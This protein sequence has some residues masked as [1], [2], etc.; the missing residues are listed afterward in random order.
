MPTIDTVRANAAGFNK[1]LTLI[2]AL[3]KDLDEKMCLIRHQKVW[4]FSFYL[5]GYFPLTINK[6]LILK[7]G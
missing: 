4:S 3:I 5:W 6:Y 1:S 2:S 7:Y